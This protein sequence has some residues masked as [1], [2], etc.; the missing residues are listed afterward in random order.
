MAQT[1]RLASFGLVFDISSRFSTFL[2]FS[3]RVFRI[4][5]PIYVKKKMVSKKNARKEKRKLTYGQNDV[6][7]VVWARFGRR[8]LLSVSRACVL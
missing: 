7:G 3:C 5:E 1:T 6:S 4:L 2:P 8:H